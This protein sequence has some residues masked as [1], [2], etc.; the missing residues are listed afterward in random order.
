MTLGADAPAGLTYR[1]SPAGLLVDPTV[2]APVTND[3]PPSAVTTFT[4]LVTNAS[5][6]EFSTTQTI[7]PPNVPPNA[8]T[9]RVICLGESVTIGSSANSPAATYAWSGTG[10]AALDDATSPAPT[11]TPTSSGTFSFTLTKTE[12]GCSSTDEV[13][14]VVNEFSLPALTSPTICQNASVRIGPTPR[15][16]VA[17]AW[18]PTTGLSDPGV[19]NPIVSG[20]TSSTTYTLS[21]IGANGCSDQATVVVGV[22]PAPA[23][24][25]S[26]PTVEACLGDAGVTFIPEISPAGT[27]TYRWSPNDGTLSDVNIEQP[28]VRLQGVGSRRYSL[29]VTSENGCSSV[30][31][32]TLDVVACPAMLCAIADAGLAD[33][34]CNNAATSATTADDFISFSLTPTAD[35]G[36]DMATYTVSVTD[37]TISPTSGIYGTETDFQLQAGS[38]G[39]GDVIVTLRDSD[40]PSCALNFTVTDPGACSFPCDLNITET[41]PSCDFDATTGQS[42]FSVEVAINWDYPN[43]TTINDSIVV[44][45]A[46][47]TETLDPAGMATGTGTVIFNNV[48]GPGPGQSVEAEFANSP[49]CFATSTADLIDCAP[50]CITVMVAESY[51]ICATQTIDL[52]MGVTVSPDS[53][54]TPDATWTTPDGQGDF[55]DATGNVLTEP[56]RY[57]TAVA[58]RP[59]PADAGRGSITFTLT[60]DDP[61]G[62]CESVSDSVTVEVLKVDCGSFLWDGR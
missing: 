12:D 59:A 14:V 7:V 41:T 31:T 13:T 38:A 6:C 26:V 30:A 39:G 27:Y 15:P 49:T 37:G 52:T 32:A 62:P 61:A 9:N 28:E 23:P 46:G 8:G 4:V 60:T 20:L 45:F 22:N 2:R 10:T 58:Y 51:T 25:V 50:D 11:F 35:N 18:S 55:L 47:Q 48:T 3:P 24:T 1:W 16:G 53:T 42:T 36:G 33:V 43:L 29:T 56:Y 57:D 17:Y 44:T 21:A 54:A 40:D 5:G 34:A 19:A